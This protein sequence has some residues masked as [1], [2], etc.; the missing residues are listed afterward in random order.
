MLCTKPCIVKFTGGHQVH[1]ENQIEF[2]AINQNDPESE[3]LQKGSINN[4]QSASRDISSDQMMMQRRENQMRSLDDQLKKMGTGDGGSHSFGEV[5]IHQM[6][7]TIE[8]ALGTVSNTASYLRLW[9]L[10]LAHTELAVTFLNLIF[11]LGPF[12]GGAMAYISSIVLWPVLWT[13][14]FGVL[15]LMDQLEC[16]LHTIRLHWVEFQNKFY[17]GDGY[18]FAPYSYSNILQQVLDSE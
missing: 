7:E 14:T 3:R 11:G 2:Q 6:I 16:F 12:K 5:F 15:M 10:S 18:K 4:D 9:A 17:K 13:V 8:F 1:E